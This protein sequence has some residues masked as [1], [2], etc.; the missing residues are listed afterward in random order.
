MAQF[1]GLIE[2]MRI[3]TKNQP[4]PEI[5]R[6]L[7]DASGLKTHYAKRTARIASRILRN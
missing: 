7:L 3:A 1:I 5:V 4:L 2:G 6:H